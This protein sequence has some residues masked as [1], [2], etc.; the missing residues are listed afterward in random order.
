MP[1]LR[2]VWFL[3][4]VAAGLALAGCAEQTATGPTKQVIAVSIAP[5]A[6]LVGQLTDG[7]ADV[8]TL[9]P[10]GAEEHD[11]E[12]TA[13]QVRQLSRAELLVLVGSGLDTWAEPKPG[14]SGGPAVLRMSD[15]I[16]T[17]K[18]DPADDKVTAAA[19]ATGG[20][21]T[22]PAATTPAAASQ[23]KSDSLKNGVA[24]SS[25]ASAKPP[26][27]PP[28]DSNAAAAQ[29]GP[30]PAPLPDTAGPNNHLWLD[31]VLVEKFVEALAGRLC[32][33]YPEHRADI[34]R[35]TRRLSSDL[36]EIDQAYRRELSAVHRREMVTFH[37]AF[38]LIARRY[39]LVIVAR[40]TDIES[41]PHGGI[42]PASYLTAIRAIKQYGLLVIYSEP[43]FPS[44]QIGA[45]ERQTAVEVLTLDPLGGPSINGYRTYQEM[46]ISNLKTLVKGQDLGAMP[47][48]TFD[49]P[50]PA[51]GFT[52]PKR[53][54]GGD[55]GNTPG[56]NS[57]RQH[58]RPGERAFFSDPS[59]SLPP[60]LPRRSS[61]RDDSLPGTSLPG[62]SLPGSL[63]PGSALPGS[64]LPGSSLP[65][66]SLPGA[67]TDSSSPAPH[68]Y[69]SSP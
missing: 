49:T 33:R 31:P 27:T 21:A 7:W 56:G 37:N 30:P 36:R 47:A 12:M 5:V 35:A 39:G 19:A 69:P 8:V 65:G 64:S 17:V 50:V 63:L 53:G 40:L 9:L 6:S 3:P 28:A 34:E 67:P 11:F 1:H 43:E 52:M 10:E 48:D 58:L 22:T 23:P 44:E 60:V 45:I 16:A 62:S 15:L 4:L 55:F 68:P 59:L 42:T 2:P 29:L 38:D 20:T 13:S 25:P 24:V 54:F 14:A 57:S 61:L 26:A 66:S 32:D 46:M 51:S 41:D 18:G